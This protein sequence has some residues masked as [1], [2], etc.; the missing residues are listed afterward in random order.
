MGKSRGALIG[1]KSMGEADFWWIYGEALGPTTRLL[2]R[3]HRIDQFDGRINPSPTKEKTTT[4][5]QLGT[6]RR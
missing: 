1:H 4:A 2:D 5:S 6:G 3:V